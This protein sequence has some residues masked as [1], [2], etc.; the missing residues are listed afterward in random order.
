MQR[1][2]LLVCLAG[3][4]IN[5][6][7]CSGPGLHSVGNAVPSV[8]DIGSSRTS[9]GQYY[10]FSIYQSTMFCEHTMSLWDWIGLLFESSTS[11]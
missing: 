9:V 7:M 10:P 6:N 11:T 8:T 2:A 4:M 1:S 3:T 5:D